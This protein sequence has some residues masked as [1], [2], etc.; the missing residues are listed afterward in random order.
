MK[1]LLEAQRVEI[2]V[3]KKAALE[4]LQKTGAIAQERQKEFD[5]TQ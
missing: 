4:K 5:D 2:D 1:E 3:V